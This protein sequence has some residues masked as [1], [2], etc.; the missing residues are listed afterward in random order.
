VNRIAS[1]DTLIYRLQ[2]VSQMLALAALLIA[3]A[4]FLGW[5]F[6]WSFIASDNRP[7]MKVMTALLFGLTGATLWRFQKK[8]INSKDALS[9]VVGCIVILGAIANLLDYFLPWTTD[10]ALRFPWLEMWIRPMSPATAL[11]LLFS[12]IGL[13]LLLKKRSEAS[14]AAA[15]AVAALALVGVTAKWYEI[16]SISHAVVFYSFSLPTA[17]CSLCVSIAMLFACPDSGWLRLFTSEV[18]GRVVRRLVPVAIGIPIFLGW[19]RLKGEE[20]GFFSNELGTALFVVALTLIFGGIAVHLAHILNRAEDQKQIASEKLRQSEIR[21]AKYARD[22]EA[23]V[24]E[25]TK[26]LKES[27]TSL[28]SLV[29]TIAH[30]L[31]APLRAMQGFT[32]ALDEEYGATLDETGKDYCRRIKGASERMDQLVS[33]LLEF[34][35]LTHREVKTRVVNLDEPVSAVLSELDDEIRRRHAEVTITKPLPKVCGEPKILEQVVFNLVSNALKFTTTQAE[36]RVQIDAERHNGQVRLW[37]RDNGIGIDRK[38][39]GRIFR[40][41]ERLHDAEQ[42]PGTGIGLAIVRTAIEKMGGTVGVDSEPGQGSRF[43]FE[44]PAGEE[45]PSN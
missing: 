14:Q 43:W 24:A 44:L 3:V 39:F 10:L 1:H 23:Q 31:R 22:L 16:N 27:V 30:D 32:A 26:K 18:G 8:E 13:L 34:G 37:V 17:V 25:R 9:L 5:V 12:G 33:D 6:H 42:Y 21:L 4:V 11:I 38:H 15:V 41:F 29:Y 7:S 20:M 40:V 19:F 2:F 36:A 35:Q 45:C 28:E